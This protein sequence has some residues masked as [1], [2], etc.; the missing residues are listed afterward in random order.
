MLVKCWKE[1]LEC[2]LILQELVL[3]KFNHGQL[4]LQILPGACSSTSGTQIALADFIV[5]KGA[6]TSATGRDMHCVR[7]TTPAPAMRLRKVYGVGTSGTQF[8]NAIDV[9]GTRRRS[10]LEMYLH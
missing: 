4:G 1:M 8:T 6:S 2:K 3:E 10:E 9:L 7:H 5:L